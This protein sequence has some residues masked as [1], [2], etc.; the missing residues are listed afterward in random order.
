MF[1]DLTE[2]AKGMAVMLRIMSSQGQKALRAVR[3]AAEVIAVYILSFITTAL[4]SS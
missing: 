1:N 2:H 4:L 3:H